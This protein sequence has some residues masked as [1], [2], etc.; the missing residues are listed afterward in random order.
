MRSNACFLV[1]VCFGA[2]AVEPVGCV[3]D[4]GMGSGLGGSSLDFAGA[5]GDDADTG[6]G[7]DFLG[8]DLAS[9]DFLTDFGLISYIFLLI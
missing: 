9:A 2:G 4:V 7:S 1:S 5:T 3:G 8:T 6:A